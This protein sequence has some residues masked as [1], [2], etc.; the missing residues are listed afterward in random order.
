MVMVAVPVQIFQEADT[1]ADYI[2]KGFQEAFLQRIK[3]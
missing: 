3:R 1:K 2:C